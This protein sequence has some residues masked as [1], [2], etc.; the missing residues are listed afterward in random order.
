MDLGISGRTAFVAA[1]SR[2]L[3]R[4]AAEALAA[5]GVHLL[6][7]ARDAG[8]LTEAAASVREAHQVRVLEVAGDLSDPSEVQRVLAAGSDEYGEW[9]AACWAA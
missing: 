8:P 9:C 7:N 3:G 4:A 1:S 5:E 6:M 2:G